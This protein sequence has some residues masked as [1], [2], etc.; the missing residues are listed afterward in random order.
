MSGDRLSAER[1]LDKPREGRVRSL[2]GKREIGRLLRM[3]L[4][5]RGA[6]TSVRR[7][8]PVSRSGGLNSGPPCPPLLTREP[9]AGRGRPGPG[10][11]ARLFLCRRRPGAAFVAVVLGLACAALSA[12]PPEWSGV[13]PHL[14]CFNDGGEC[15]TGAVVPWADRLWV[16]TYAPHVPNGSSDKLYEITDDLRRD[17]APGEHWRNAGESDDS[18]RIRI[19]SSSVPTRSM[20]ERRVRV[21]PYETMPGPAHGQRAAPDRS[22]EQDLLRDDGGR[23]LRS[24]SSSRSRS[25]S[26]IPTPIRQSGLTRVAAARLPR[27]GCS[28][29]ARAAWSTPTTAS[30][31]AEAHA[32]TGCPLGLPGGVGRHRTGQVV[33]PEPVHRSHWSGRNRGQS[34]PRHRSDLEHRLGSS[35]ADP[36]AARRRTLARVPAAQG[37]PLLRRCARLEHRMAAHPRHRRRGPADD[38]ARDVLAFPTTFSAGQHGRHPTALDLP[39]GD[40]RLLPLERPA[41]LRLRRHG[42]E[43]VPQQA[44][45]QGPT[46]RSR[47]SR[48][49]T[50][51]SPTRRVWITSVPPFGP[52][53]GVDERDRVTA[54]DSGPTLTCSPGTDR[55]GVHLA[56]RR[57]GRSRSS[58]TWIAKGTAVGAAQVEVA[59]PARGY[60]WL[61]FPA[62]EPGEWIR[63][64]ADSDAP[65]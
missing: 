63:V 64:R 11:R 28:T 2:P 16:M 15:G 35:L 51:G 34:R 49:P 14:A 27:Q 52:R 45:G 62:A 31:S 56:H 4:R 38:D 22:G 30:T 17:R 8:D 36:D 1:P 26:S 18:S 25:R 37:E 29:P 23:L 7:T 5:T 3:N 50:S 61:E 6:R 24:R 20:R 40:R 47:A 53:G 46:R 33:A 9:A 48:N 55:R 44:S 58:S 21:I 41:G 54:G 43:R 13:H 59:V 12:A 39:Q 32:A 19:S 60:V 42:Q 10:L 57:S 65:K